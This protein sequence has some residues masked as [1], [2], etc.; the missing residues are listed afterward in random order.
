MIDN[1][2]TARETLRKK[3]AMW[4]AN[5]ELSATAIPALSFIRH[6]HIYEPV[7]GLHEPSVCLSPRGPNA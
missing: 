7:C 5:G 2:E 4:T 6:N 1:I 3:I